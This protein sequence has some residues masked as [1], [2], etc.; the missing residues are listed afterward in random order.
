M[1]CAF[2]AKQRTSLC[3]LILILILIKIL[4]FLVRFDFIA[5]HVVVNFHLGFSH[6]SNIVIF[7]IMNVDR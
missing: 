5:N 1:M 2:L 6:S 7:V 3:N 4:L